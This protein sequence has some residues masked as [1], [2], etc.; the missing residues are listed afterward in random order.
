MNNTIKEKKAEEI[1]CFDKWGEGYFHKNS[2][3]N[4]EVTPYKK[5]E[6]VDLYEIVK[7]ASRPRNRSSNFNTF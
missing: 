4:I 2:K 1:Y 5:K 3:G 6:G 7:N